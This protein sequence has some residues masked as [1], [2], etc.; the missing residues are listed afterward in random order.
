MSTD[1]DV[2]VVGAGMAGLAAACTVQRQGASVAVLEAR[3]RLGGR[4]DTR[5]LRGVP[6]ELG[7]QVLH[8]EANQVLALLEPS[9]ARP[10]RRGDV[11]ASLLDADGVR[12]GFADA[13]AAFVSPA[14]LTARLQAMARSLGDRAAWLTLG[15]ALQA[16]RVSPGTRTALQSW[17]EQATGASADQVPLA[18]ICSDRVRQ[19]HGDSEHVVP[20][21][22]H[23]VVAAL[24]QDLH[25]RL[26]WVVTRVAA[27][28]AG[29]RVEAGTPGGDGTLSAHAAVVTVPPPLVGTGTLTVD[30]LPAEQRAAAA[31]L[32]LADAVAAVVP[33]AAPAPYDGFLFD[34][35]GPLGFVSWTRGSRHLTVIAKGTAAARL[36]ALLAAQAPDALLRAL[37]A[38][39]PSCTV[40]SSALPL[41][42]DWGTD[43]FATGAFTAP[44]ARMVAHS[45][46]WRTPVGGRV[47]F[48]GESTDCGSGAPFLDRAWSTGVRAAQQALAAVP[49]G[50]RS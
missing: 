39:V 9:A 18:E 25:V 14:V 24:G 7:A 2:V 41:V 11:S 37:A 10:V 44:S 28:G 49:V 20:A 15:A 26:G 31:A 45:Q 38:A 3:D 29:I 27:G 36:R 23:S 22:L 17:Y 5:L 16:T 48:A 6:V 32:A 40:D 50:A 21:G 42:Q 43:P 34:V 13:D 46:R 33:L 47:F 30:G 4:V 8:G 19:Y 12:R 1:V 35:A